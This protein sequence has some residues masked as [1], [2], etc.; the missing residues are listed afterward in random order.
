MFDYN[1]FDYKYNIAGYSGQHFDGAERYAYMIFCFVAIPVLVYLLRKTS[2]RRMTV[3]FRYLAVLMILLEITKV[4]WESYWDVATGRGFNFGGI[5]PLDTCSLFLFTLPFAGFGSGK[6]KEC[7]TAWLATLGLAGGLSNVLFI[8]ALKWYPILS[9]GAF[10]SMFYHFMMVFVALWIVASGYLKFS[11]RHT[12]YAFLPHVVFSVPVIILD[13]IFGWDYMLYREASGVPVLSGAADRLRESGMTWLVTVI[14]LA[15]Y[16]GLCAGLC[17]LYTFLQ[18]KVA[19]R[20][21]G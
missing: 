13:Y 16:L 17:G 9:F 1:F 20:R 18:K 2:H 3:F 14:M 5:L 7:A 8:Q 6:V 11:F 12:L 10:F 15:V 4:S 21:A 19:E